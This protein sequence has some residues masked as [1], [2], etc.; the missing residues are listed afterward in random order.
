MRDGTMN[1]H[2]DGDATQDDGTPTVEQSADQTAEQ[3]RRWR[4]LRAR[5]VVLVVVAALASVALAVGYVF[6]DGLG[7]IPGALTFS[8]VVDCPPA[9]LRSARVGATLV[10]DADLTRTIDKNK[11]AAA[12]DTLIHTKGVGNEV[13]VLVLQPDGTTAAASAQ[14]TA[15]EPAST[16]KTLTALAAASTLD[17]GSTF[18][19]STH[20]VHEQDGADTLILQGGGDMLLGAGA[21]DPRHVNGRAGLG[22]L[23]ERTAS[24]LGKRG[25]TKVRLA[26]D[27]TMFGDERSPKRIAENNGDHLY[28]TPVSSM[29]V[30]G[31]RQRADAG[32]DPDRFSDYPP[33]SQ[34]TAADAA[35]IFA[36]RL[37]EHG[38]DVTNADAL[39]QMRTPEGRT[40]LASVESATLSAVMRFM[41]QHSDNTLAEQF[42]RLLALHMKTGNSPEAAVKAVRTRLEALGVPLDGLV[43]ADCSGLSPG[44]RLT[45]TTLADVQLR[46]IEVGVAPAAAEGLSV[47]G[48]V[49]TAASRLADDAAAGLMRVKTGSLGT[50]TSMTGNVSRKDGGV[51]MFSVIVNNPSDMA[52]ARDAIDEF[53][54]TLTEL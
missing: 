30:D 31:G 18:T 32:A 13:S 50:V 54:A 47:P 16:M 45:V 49:G 44:S 17:M 6:A 4:H 22:T 23:A 15:R 42:G 38:V 3:A 53:V 14:D 1:P 41:L 21:S 7:V 11:A 9:A 48:L 51:A 8:S 2:T 5:R 37:T 19:T 43:M 25:V 29:A 20:L 46:N 36:T 52:V 33:L 28:Y 34:T 10:A 26:W 27:D 39:Q 40:P 24:A 35:A 12:I